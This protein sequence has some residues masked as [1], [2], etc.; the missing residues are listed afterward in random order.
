MSVTA[1]GMALD[2]VG[3]SPRAKLVLLALCNNAYEETFTAFPSRRHLARAADC[4]VDTVDRCLREL[5]D[6][7]LIEKTER[8]RDDGKGQTSNQYRVFPT[9]DPSR[10]NA[11]GGRIA[12]GGNAETRPPQPQ[13]YAA[14]PAA[15]DAAPKEP[16]SEPVDAIAVARQRGRENAAMAEEAKERAGAAVNLTCGYVHHGQDLRRLLD[17]GCDWHEDVLPAIDAVSAG[18]IAR[19][20][21]LIN[22][23]GHPGIVE[24]ALTL[25]DRRLAGLPPP[26]PVSETPRPM[27]AAKPSMASVIDRMEAEGRLK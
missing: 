14:P 10:K 19:K 23:W 1:L 3:I 26:Q 11:E 24:A 12:A 21:K 17:A 18:I 13:A 20:G 8:E 5:A 2:V 6:I 25:R 4:S 16:Y 27:R 15:R 9:Y 22:S 7:M